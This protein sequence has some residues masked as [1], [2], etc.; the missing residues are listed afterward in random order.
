MIRCVFR[1]AFPQLVSR[2]TYYILVLDGDF[3]GMRLL[4]QEPII[5]RADGALSKSLGIGKA[6]LVVL[7]KTTR[8]G[9]G[10]VL[11]WA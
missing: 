9:L 8:V 3:D 4:P 7:K 5:F 11:P 1:C 6:F 10:A 2:G